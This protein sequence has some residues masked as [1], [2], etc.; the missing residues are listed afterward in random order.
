MIPQRR[1]GHGL[2][3]SLRYIQADRRK[4]ARLRMLVAGERERIDGWEDDGR[5]PRRCRPIRIVLQ[6]PASRRV[7]NIEGLALTGN[8]AAILAATA[9]ASHRQASSP[10]LAR[11]SPLFA[12]P[13]PAQR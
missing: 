5:I 9:R 1:K 2:L 11:R 4:E 12:D 6:A 13:P 7:P 10:S 8:H 3:C